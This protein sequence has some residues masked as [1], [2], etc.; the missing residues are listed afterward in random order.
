MRSSHGFGSIFHLAGRFF[1]SLLPI[2]P[3][4]A[5]EDWAMSH[6]LTEEVSLFKSMSNADRRHAIGVA[7]RAIRLFDGADQRAGTERPREFVAAALLHDV[8]KVKAGLGTF[9][10]VAATVVA[11]GLGRAKVVSWTDWPSDSSNERR[12]AS[13]VQ[14]HECQSPSPSRWKPSSLK[15]DMGRYLTHDIIGARL[16]EE[17]GSDGFT[18]RW[19]REHHLPES[20]WTVEHK[21]GI[22]L[23]QA[24]GD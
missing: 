24:D 17:A 16:L 6:L 2:A 23:K 9:G 18:I 4:E 5:D 1:G 20:G 22:A 8:G 10:R 21:L 7:R 12:D 14:R 11:V 15:A 13:G 19:A 3:K